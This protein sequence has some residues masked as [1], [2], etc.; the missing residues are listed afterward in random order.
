M[1]GHL[2][3]WSGRT[4]S[5][6]TPFVVPG[7]SVTTSPQLRLWLTSVFPA[8]AGARGYSPYVLWGSQKNAP[9]RQPQR[10]DHRSAYNE[11]VIIY[12][13]RTDGLAGLGSTE[14]AFAE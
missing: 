4:G 7:V 9:Q 12:I 6:S 13:M 10:S 14:L 8:S 2:E 1:G 5:G 3:G 11:F